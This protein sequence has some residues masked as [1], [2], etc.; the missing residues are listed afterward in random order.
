MGQSRFGV[1]QVIFEA[2][3]TPTQRGLD[4]RQLDISAEV[5]KY[6]GHPLVNI[7]STLGAAF[8]M[9]NSYAFRFVFPT[10][11]VASDN[12][13]FSGRHSCTIVLDYQNIHDDVI[14]A[15]INM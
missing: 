8:G 1:E 10:L 11:L 7:N 5:D 12:Q 9:P 14:R 2:S 3:A 13:A 15:Q 4:Q 6:H